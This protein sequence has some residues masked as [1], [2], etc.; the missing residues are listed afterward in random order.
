MEGGITLWGCLSKS[1]SVLLPYPK[2][3]V[4]KMSTCFSVIFSIGDVVKRIAVK[5]GIF[6]ARVFG[7]C[8]MIL[9]GWVIYGGFEDCGWIDAGE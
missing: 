2:P 6:E 7:E 8:P 5:F 1:R 3:M 4:C 9:G